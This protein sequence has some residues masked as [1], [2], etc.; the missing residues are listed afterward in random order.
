MKLS[1][2]PISLDRYFDTDKDMRTILE[3]TRD[4]GFTY[5]DYDI[6]Q[7]YLDGDYIEIA[8]RLKKNLTELGITAAQAH[9]PIINPFNPGEVD[10]MDAYR[11]SLHFCQIV[12]IPRIVIHAGCLPDN[13]K[14]E[15]MANNIAFYRS[16]IPFMEETGVEI[17]LENIGHYA[18]SYYLRN[19]AELRE[20]I[21]ALD[22][23]MFGACWDVGHANLYNKKDCEQYS[24]VVA[25]GDKLKAL[26]VHDNCGYFEKSYRHHRID[27]HT[28]P[29]V[30]LYAS[31]NYDALMQ[32]LVD[33]GYQGTFNF[34]TNAPV[35]PVRFSFEY[36]GEIVRK[37]EKLPIPLWKQMNVLLYD[38][39]KFM[40]ETYGLFE[41]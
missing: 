33:I 32:G 31:V 35:P 18:D 25:L 9:A 6:K 7:K 38:I 13:T 22:H 4:C 28:M 41:G 14:E 23:P 16:M 39:G 37:L 40:L 1:L 30:S 5:I 27:M 34:E 15:F 10:Y 8:E 17:L 20:L 11:K 2:A 12:G 24:S 21:D 29:Y 19:G 26:H 3:L 36:E